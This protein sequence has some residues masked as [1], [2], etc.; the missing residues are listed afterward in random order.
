M[1]LQNGS[2]QTVV[3]MARLWQK[4]QISHVVSPSHSILTQ[5][6]L[7]LVRIDLPVSCTWGGSFTNSGTR[8]DLTHICALKTL[9][10]MH[11]L[12]N[13]EY[14]KV[15]IEHII[16][17]P[18]TWKDEYVPQTPLVP[19]FQQGI[20]HTHLCSDKSQNCTQINSNDAVTNSFTQ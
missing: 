15:L 20:L 7:V 17:L 14:K 2:A 10:Q 19:D 11:T 18:C 5:G 9:K 6:Q 16:H 1:H 4:L 8:P 12:A 3:C 13:S